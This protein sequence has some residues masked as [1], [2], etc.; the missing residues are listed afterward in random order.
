VLT[1]VFDPPPTNIAIPWL[2]L[3]SLAVVATVTVIVAALAAI[4]S[5]HRPAMDVLRDL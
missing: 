1:G 5:A 2:Y 4:R 3:G